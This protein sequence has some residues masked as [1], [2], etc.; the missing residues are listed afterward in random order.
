MTDTKKCKECHETHAHLY[1]IGA[2]HV[3]AECVSFNETLNV[4]QDF[5]TSLT[6]WL[7]QAQGI[8]NDAWTKAG[9]TH[10]KPPLLTLQCGQ[11]NIKVVRTD[12]NGNGPS[13]SVHCF[14]DIATGDVL[15]A[16][17]WKAAAKHARGS[18]YDTSRPGVNQYGGIYL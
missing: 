7:E 3:H 17:S 6:R 12:D 18:I 4:L 5:E 2:E 8:I 16:A 9:Y 11:K 15:K 1:A 13:R 10:A 14:I